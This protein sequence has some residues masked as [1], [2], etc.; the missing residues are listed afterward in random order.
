[1][2]EENQNGRIFIS[3]GHDDSSAFAL[4]LA[5]FL[6]EHGYEVYIDKEGIRT[7]QQWE[8]RLEDGLLWANDGTKKGV[9][10]LLMTPYSVQRPDGYCLNEMLY[11]LD[12]GLKMVPVMLKTVTPPLSIYRLQYLDLTDIADDQNSC[13]PKILHCITDSDNTSEYKASPLMPLMSDLAPF[14]FSSEINLFSKDFVGRKWVLPMIDNWAIDHHGVLAITGAP[15]TGKTALAVFLYNHLSDAIA[16]YMFRRNDTAKLS[17]QRFIGTIAYEIATQN[18]EYQH[19]LQSCNIK[20]LIKESPSRAFQKLIVEPLKEIKR[21]N[22]PKF[23]IIDGLDE[24][25]A[26]SYNP[27][28]IFLNE[29][30]HYL[31]NWVNVIITSRKYESSLIAIDA[32][33]IFELN[34]LDKNN[35]LDIKRYV[36]DTMSFLDE[37]KRTHIAENSQGSFLY[38]KHISELYR[39][40]RK[41]KEEI[42][43][44]IFSYYHIL[45]AHIFPSNTA[46]TNGKFF[47]ELLVS[48]PIPL[49]R[50][51]LQFAAC[52]TSYNLE[53]FLAN[54]PTIINEGK[55]FRI[56]LEHSTLAEWLSS[57]ESGCYQIDSNVGRQ[58]IAE[59]IRSC[60]WEDEDGDESTTSAEK[61]DRHVELIE[62][63]LGHSFD[64]EIVPMY[65]L[66]MKNNE[67][68]TSFIDFSYWYLSS[69]C[70]SNWYLSPRCFSNIVELIMCICDEN[71][72]EIKSHP[73][74]AH[75]DKGLTRSLAYTYEYMMKKA[76]FGM[77][78]R[79]SYPSSIIFCRLR[80]AIENTT[81][82]SR[83]ADLLRSI[84]SDYPNLLRVFS[85]YMFH[86]EADCADSIIDLFLN[87]RDANRIDDAE[88]LEWMNDVKRWA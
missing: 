16:F 66:M 42:P 71:Y 57:E 11:A 54:F 25:E 2:S 83:L 82:D 18:Q 21:P 81:N 48:S 13:F 67:D 30:F 20:E 76:Q 80:S 45:F 72:E 59:I 65:C 17:L 6:K 39:A 7:G 85:S 86:C 44:N 14:D 35:L 75:I 61:Y 49:S 53:E 32:D 62:S 31:P 43:V 12:L 84:K 24:A 69:L 74:Y 36:D 9:F 5:N 15:G 23:I 51:F 29:H 22:K 37:E 3:Y 58:R 46:Y 50:N 1:M 73:S 78:T 87:I 56:R 47:L 41:R 70:F 40:D 63:T 52:G 10:I 60:F 26:E 38:V 88:L 34:P 79:L 68:W 55:D 77:I 8:S 28:A 27:T 19:A 4:S 33:T 64:N